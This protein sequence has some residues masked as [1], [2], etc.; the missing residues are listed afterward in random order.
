MKSLFLIAF[1]LGSLSVQAA[2]IGPKDNRMTYQE[3]AAVKFG[4]NLDT[5][6][7]QFS[8]SGVL[9]CHDAFESASIVGKNDVIVMA[10]HST[11]EKDRS[12]RCAPLSTLNQCY[13]QVLS[14]NG[15]PGRRIPIEPTSVRSSRNQ[16][17]NFTRFSTDWA[18]GRLKS[19]ATEVTPY[20]PYDISKGPIGDP[21][22]QWLT[23]SQ[24]ITLAAK[25]ENFAGHSF[26]TATVCDGKIGYVWPMKDPAGTYTFGLGT[27][28]SS[29]P[30]NS[31]GAILLNQDGIY[32]L[33]PLHGGSGPEMNYRPFGAN[34]CSGSSL[35]QGEF[36]QTL[37]GM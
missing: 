18:V 29:G 22:L 4:G 28:C 20:I 27:D 9:F 8:A 17:C 25:N 30:G 10:A 6:Y 16:D 26:S 11:F 3:Y 15:T 7:R 33:G 23:G 24:I 12:G 35:L 32:F 19:P 13:F 34:N 36:Y 5:F 2:I 21:F 1:C 31:G 37:M 14:K